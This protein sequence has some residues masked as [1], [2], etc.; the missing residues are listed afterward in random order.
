[1]K[2][3][4]FVVKIRELA[5]PPVRGRELKLLR[6]VEAFLGSGRPPCGGVN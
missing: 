6:V 5:S 4:Q 2:L 3:E 1:M